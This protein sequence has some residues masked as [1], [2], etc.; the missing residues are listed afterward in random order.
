M[1]PR[2]STQLFPRTCRSL[3]YM[4][5]QRY[6]TPADTCPAS[7]YHRFNGACQLRFRSSSDALTIALSPLPR[8]CRVLSAVVSPT[9]EYGRSPI[10]AA[11]SV[12]IASSTSIRNRVLLSENNTAA[13]LETCPWENSDSSSSDSS[14]GTATSVRLIFAPTP[15]ENAISAAATASP[16]SLRSW[17]LRIKPC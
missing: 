15:P 13:G 2:A 14:D 1:A 7:E 9:Q 17:Q 6:R 11:K 3:G 5:G 10:T 4:D 16:P 8:I 12:A